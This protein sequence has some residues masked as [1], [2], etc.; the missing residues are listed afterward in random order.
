MTEKIGKKFIR[1]I[2]ILALV[3]A[4][5]M[6]LG[7][8]L[9]KKNKENSVDETADK[10]AGEPFFISGKTW[11]EESAALPIPHQEMLDSE[12]VDAKFARY[13][14]MWVCSY[15]ETLNRCL[16]G[17]SMFMP[18]QET[19]AAPQPMLRGNLLKKRTAEQANKGLP[20]CIACGKPRT[21]RV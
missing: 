17:D 10:P 5:L 12:T 2:I 7:W 9:G 18:V 8:F 11:Q 6:G 1:G 3:V 14:H 21:R 16:P 19:V 20:E 4:F 15:C 13:N